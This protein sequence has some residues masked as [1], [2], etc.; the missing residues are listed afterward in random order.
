MSIAEHI[1]VTHLTDQPQPEEASIEA[2]PAVT[3]VDLVQVPA[4]DVV[5]E[6]NVRTAADLDP[7]FLASVKRHGVLL[8]TIGYRYGL[9]DAVVLRSRLWSVKTRGA[10]LA[11]DW[12]LGSSGIVALAYVCVLFVWSGLLGA[13]FAVPPVAF[14]VVVALGALVVR[15]VRGAVSL[16]AWLLLLLTTAVGSVLLLPLLM[17]DEGD[18]YGDLLGLWSMVMLP[19]AALLAVTAFIVRRVARRRNRIVPESASETE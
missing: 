5:I 17:L 19:L 9:C 11:L 15:R 10:P 12:T 18:P 3:G 7:A 8:P 14:M 16:R 6:D 13:L 1:T 2:A 4:A